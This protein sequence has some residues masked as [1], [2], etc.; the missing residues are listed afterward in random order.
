M[1]VLKE[2]GCYSN[3]QA[4]I[5]RVRVGRW[6]KLD[7]D[8]NEI[9]LRPGKT[10]PQDEA[11][12][13]GVIT[14]EFQDFRLAVDIERHKV[15]ELLRVFVADKG[16]GLIGARPAVLPIVDHHGSPTSD[17]LPDED[18]REHNRHPPGQPGWRARPMGIV[19]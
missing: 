17:P 8:G 6:H 3:I 12:V 18:E 5:R 16:I 13:R 4:H 15:A 11:S 1:A 9:R 14:R 7:G 10:R 19:P 2:D